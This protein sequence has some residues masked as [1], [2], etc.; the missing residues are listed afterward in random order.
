[1]FGSSIAKPAPAK[2]IANIDADQVATNQQATPVPYLLGRGRLP[3]H[4]IAPVYNKRTEKLTTQTGKDSSTTVG[5]VYFGDIA[6]TVCCCGS[7]V[8]L[9]KLYKIIIESQVVWENTAGLDVGDPYSPV[10]IDGYGSGRLYAGT[11][12]QPVD[13]LVLTPNSIVIPPGVDPRKTST[14]PNGDDTKNIP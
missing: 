6:A 8:P 1:M 5:F 14:W 3:L 12:N 10:T 4:Y 2:K 11:F 13:D 7:R 9:A